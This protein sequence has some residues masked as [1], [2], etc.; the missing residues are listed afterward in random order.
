VPAGT[1]RPR[2]G[3]GVAEHAPDLRIRLQHVVEIGRH[4]ADDG[5]RE[6]VDVQRRAD[7]RAIAPEPPREQP[8]TQDDDAV[9]RRGVVAELE[10]ASQPWPDAKRAEVLPGDALPLDTLAVR[11]AEERWL[12]VAER[13]A[14]QQCRR[15][16]AQVLVRL[17][18][19][20]TR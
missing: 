3:L 5:A 19:D 13:G 15:P 4:H 9:V 2:I 12:P 14:V 18:T 6:P 17:K 11:L 8:M 7:H 10:V 1:A 20:A 16:L